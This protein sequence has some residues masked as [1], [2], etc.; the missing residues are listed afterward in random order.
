MCVRFCKKFLEKFLE[1]FY[2]LD[3]S[4][5][6][7]FVLVNMRKVLVWVRCVKV[8]VGIYWF[9][10][11]FLVVKVVVFDKILCRVSVLLFCLLIYLN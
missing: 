2:F 1:S 5:I 7:M 9:D 11:I 3:E 10:D 6:R 4:E 8:I